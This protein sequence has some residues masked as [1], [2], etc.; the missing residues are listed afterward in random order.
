MSNHTVPPLQCQLETNESRPVPKKASSHLA[1]LDRE[2]K[3]LHILTANGRGWRSP[4]RGDILVDTEYFSFVCG[5]GGAGR[6]CLAFFSCAGKTV[7]WYTAW[8]SERE[9]TILAGA[10]IKRFFG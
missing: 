9:F 2:R 6:G 5:P 10:A 7:L 8:Y 1:Y 4:Q 3:Y